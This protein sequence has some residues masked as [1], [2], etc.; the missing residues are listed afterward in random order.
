MT[1]HVHYYIIGVHRRKNSRITHVVVANRDP[2]GNV[3]N[4]PTTTYTVDQVAQHIDDQGMVVK[5][6]PMIDGLRQP[7]SV[8][9]TTKRNGGRYIHALANDRITDNLEALT[10]YQE[11]PV[12][13]RYSTLAY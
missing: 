9:T 8:V 13:R 4:F 11:L 5:T 1:D 10:S 3:S 6:A 7:G 12:F 2:S